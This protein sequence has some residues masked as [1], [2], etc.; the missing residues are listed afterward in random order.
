MSQPPHSRARRRIASAGAAL[1]LVL[2]SLVGGAALPAQAADIPSMV[3]AS[4]TDQSTIDLEGQTNY[5]EVGYTV[6]VLD[7]TTEVCPGGV[8]DGAGSF[9]CDGIDLALG[10]NTFTVTTD[11][12]S[13]TDGATTDFVITR[14]APA[15]IVGIQGVVGTATT[16][17]DVTLTG[18][19]PALGNIEIAVSAAATPVGDLCQTTADSSGDWSCLLTPTLAVGDY[20]AVAT[21][22]GTGGTQLSS[23]APYSFSVITDPTLATAITID[24]PADTS[25]VL[26]SDYDVTG[27]VT[28]ADATVTVSAQGRSCVATVIGT[29]WTCSLSGL[30]NGVGVA[31]SASTSDN[32]VLATSTVDVVLPPVINGLVGGKLYGYDAS[33]TVTGVVGVGATVHVEANNP[34]GECGANESDND[35]DEIPGTFECTIDASAGFPFTDGEYTMLVSQSLGAGSNSTPVNIII[36]T[37]PGATVD[38][39]PSLV[40]DPTLT[41]TGTTDY[42]TGSLIVELGNDSC[43]TTITGTELPF[44]WSCTFYNLTTANNT[45][46]TVKRGSGAPVLAAATVDVL[47][48]PSFNSDTTDDGGNPPG[49]GN[50]ITI[51]G[52]GEPSTDVE[53]GGDTIIT[54]TVSGIVPP[55]T[56]TTTT[57]GSDGE[58]YPGGYWY[59]TLPPGIPDGAYPIEITQTP[60]WSG[61]TA[62]EPLAKTLYVDQNGGGR[63]ALNCSFSAGGLTV[64]KSDPNNSV[65]LYYVGAVPG[66]Y[67]PV[68][69]GTCSGA[70]GAPAPAS[71][72]DVFRGE[73]APGTDAQP[74]LVSTSDTTCLVTNL[75][76]GMWNLYYSTEEGGNLYWDWFFI[77]PSPPTLSPTSTGVPGVG[78]FRGTGTPGD[79]ITVTTTDGKPVCTAVVAPNGVWACTATVGTGSAAYRASQTDA[80]TG[81]VSPFTT[82]TA[83]ISFAAAPDPVVDTTVPTPTPT[84]KVPLHWTLTIS[85]VDGPLRPGQ[86]VGLSSS[87]LPAG[88]IVDVELHS[89]PVHLGNTIVRPDGTFDFAVTIP[90]DVTRGSHKIIVTVTAPGEDPS[91]VESAVDV[92][93]DLVTKALENTSVG[94][95]PTSDAPSGNGSDVTQSRNDPSSPTAISGALPTLFDIIT[96]PGALAVAGGLALMILL[97]VALPTEVLNSTIESNSGRFGRGFSAIQRAITRGTEWFIAV[98]RTPLI[99]TVVLLVLTSFIFGFVD[100][101]FG[102]DLASLRLVLS[103][104]LGLFVVTFVASRLTGLVLHRRWSVESAIEMDP[105]AII[106]A[107]LGVVVA[108]L[109]DFSPGFLV[110]LVIGL[111]LA[112]Q[113]T[114]SQKIRAIVVEFSF[115]V[116]FG[117]LAWLAYSVWVGVQGD[118]VLGFW[119]G[120]VQDALVAVTSEGLT[121]VT[122]AMIPIAFLDGKEIFAHSR[123][124]WAV[125]F[126]IAAT[127]FALLILPTSVGGDQVG[128]I[129]VWIAVL[130]GFAAVTL[131]LTLW[132]QKTSNAET[133]EEKEEKVDA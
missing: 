15:Q 12:G 115:I 16:S 4:E 51:D 110:G 6:S 25:V 98:T 69:F 96:N 117:V 103:L 18:T 75:T 27:T 42:S 37:D 49:F 108:R 105:S 23:S 45:H 81:G 79:T 70:V 24:D 72:D 90:M 32:T 2:A 104:A 128:N 3:S 74:W 58:G 21:G 5:I 62:S 11:D 38:P 63:G 133:T 121:A 67:P 118:A 97:L 84:T 114:T 78:G 50:P 44:T 43:T 65:S 71:F 46:V 92:E 99:A 39:L 17:G 111:E 10:T 109:L 91:P 13:G 123:R 29:D 126:L 106:F 48:P 116:G 57:S 68:H 14:Y 73:C 61:G 101:S 76:P 22:Y 100:P 20:D 55:I 47:Q 9:Y 107:I 66:S 120:M 80:A 95:S 93:T 34:D 131:G 86:K 89:T 130:V 28:P 122:V 53:I 31:I 35:P 127:V 88:S 64:T 60:A 132:L 59:C 30:E 33:Y 7:G 8:I 82:P 1:C 94:H 85:G 129:A 112:H 36:N 83:T 87:G 113:A 54:V 56:C 119:D 41:V 77:V 52:E 102:F 40:T 26:H 124:L 19:G 125:M